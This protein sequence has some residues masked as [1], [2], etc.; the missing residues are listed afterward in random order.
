MKKKIYLPSA[1]KPLYSTYV[2]I[3]KALQIPVAD[4]LQIKYLQHDYSKNYTLIIVRLA[5]V[6]LVSL[7]R[8]FGIHT[9]KLAFP[10]QET[11]VS[12]GGNERFSYTI[13]YAK[14]IVLQ[15]PYLQHICNRY[16]QR[17]NNLN[18]SHIQRF[19]CRWQIKNS[20]S[21]F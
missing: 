6:L 3:L 8:N 7:R 21:N 2:Q 9:G 10:T 11:G 1:T 4:V 19:C 20:F 15:I 12:I 17:I 13:Y 14:R 5:E 16:L 18:T